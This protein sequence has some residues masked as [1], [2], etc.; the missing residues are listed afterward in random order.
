MFVLESGGKPISRFKSIEHKHDM[1]VLLWNLSSM[2]V[3]LYMWLTLWLINML[4][5]KYT[6]KQIFAIIFIII[7][8]KTAL[9]SNVVQ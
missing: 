5:N 1:T 3:Y 4:W 9:W 6:D 8:I 7:I 2:Y